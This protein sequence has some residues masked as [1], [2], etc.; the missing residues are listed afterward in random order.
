MSRRRFTR[1]SRSGK[2]FCAGISSETF[3]E[4]GYCLASRVV[5]RRTAFPTTEAMGS[6]YDIAWHSWSPSFYALPRRTYY[7]DWEYNDDGTQEGWA[8]DV[9]RCNGQPLSFDEAV[10]F[11]QKL[12]LAPDERLG[13]GDR[14]A[15]EAAWIKQI[16]GRQRFL[17]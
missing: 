14:R 7:L 1:V 4:D 3:N 17:E 10:R 8:L 13:P 11:E 5:L 12:D 9:E 15:Y 6:D 16:H 2:K